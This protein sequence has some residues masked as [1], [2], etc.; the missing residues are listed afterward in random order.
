MNHVLYNISPDL[1]WDWDA[2]F[3]NHEIE[4]VECVDVTEEVTNQVNSQDNEQYDNS[5]DV[6]AQ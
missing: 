6:Q 4:D 3:A 2:I 1:E 5:S